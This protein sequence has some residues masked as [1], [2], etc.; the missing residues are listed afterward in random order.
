MEA[1]VGL[2]L[3][4]RKFA[5]QADDR[6]DA[7]PQKQ[8]LDAARAALTYEFQSDVDGIPRYALDALVTLGEAESIEVK[9]PKPHFLFRRRV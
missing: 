6:E 8:L 4:V 5:A 7:R 3:A 2:R 9:Y 1:D